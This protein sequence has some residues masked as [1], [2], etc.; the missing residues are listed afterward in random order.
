MTVELDALIERLPQVDGAELHLASDCRPAWRLDGPLSELEDTGPWSTQRLRS[1]LRHLVDERDW[2]ELER[3]GSLRCRSERSATGPIRIVIFEQTD[4]L[5]AVLRPL[6]RAVP[7]AGELGLPETV[8]AWTERNAG[9]VLLASPRAS[10]KSHSAAALVART[11]TAGPRH[12]VIVQ[13]PIEF[14]HRSNTSILSHRQPGVDVTNQSE[15]VRGARSAD[16]DVLVVDELTEP[17]A[18]VS[19]LRMAAS[20]SLVI[21]A[22]AATDCT[23]AIRRLLRSAPPE[24]RPLARY[25]L[26]RSFIGATT[27]VLCSTTGF[28]RIAAFE[29]LPTSDALVRAIEIE[30]YA[31]FWDCFPESRAAGARLLDDSLET[32]VEQRRLPVAEALRWA[33][34]PE[35]FRTS[36][37]S[38]LKP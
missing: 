37:A 1:A 33:R 8:I 35:R 11:I 38:A 13:Q 9:L 30:D 3:S 16:A 14:V 6:P 2:H 18:I 25:L 24:D 36:A 32:L 27:Q 10:G 28:E 19:A 12:I 17:A 7:S 21:A 22:V 29:V 31:A 5:G 34:V 4:G 26:S 15:A 20:G 23:A